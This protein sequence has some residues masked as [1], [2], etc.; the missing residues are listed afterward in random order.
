M[1][2][3]K[4]T[5]RICIS[6]HFIRWYDAGNGLKM[7]QDRDKWQLVRDLTKEEMEEITKENNGYDFLK[8][9]QMEYTAAFIKIIKITQNWKVIG[10]F[11]NQKMMENA[12]ELAMSKNDL[13][14]VWMV[15]NLKTVYKSGKSDQAKPSITGNEKEKINL[16]EEEVVD[17]IKDWRIREKEEEPESDDSSDDDLGINMMENQPIDPYNVITLTRTKL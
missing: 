1:T 16:E 14:K 6:K 7:R 13:A 17:M 15:H 11:S 9:M 3:N 2:F 8:K 5:F 4:G 12:V 10:Y